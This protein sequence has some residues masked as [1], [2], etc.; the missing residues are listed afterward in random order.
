MSD[1]TIETFEY[2]AE[3]K[4][5]LHLIIH[6]LYTHPEVFLRE[7][8]SNASDA[9]NKVRY[10][11]LSD[12]T[13]I[14]KDSAL[15]IKISFDK[16]KKIFAI[17]DSGIGMTKE[18]LMTNIGT[19]ARSGTLE[20]LQKRQKEAKEGETGEGDLIGK[21]GVGFYSV[22]MVTDKVTIETRHASKD[23]QGLRWVS[24]GEGSYSIEDI[25]KET[26]GT[27][28]SFEVKESASE[29][30]EDYRVKDIIK[31]YSNFADFPIVIGDETINTVD[32]L[33]RKS[34]NDVT[35]DERNEF[36]KFITNDFEDPFGNLHLSIEGGGAEF[37]AL[38]FIPK[39]AA[40]DLIRTQQHKTVQLYTNKIMIMEDC[41][42]LLPEYLHFIRG[43]VD[44]SELSLNVSRETVQSSPVLSKIR[45]T[46]TTK[47]LQWLQRLA[48]KEPAKYIEFYKIFGAL[49]KSGLSADF[50]NRDKLIELMRF[51]SSKLKSEE[52]TSFKEYVGRMKEVDKNIYYLS[53]DNREVAQRNPNLEYFNKHDLEVLFLLDPADVFLVPSINEYDKKE[54]K[55]IDKGDID[56]EEGTDK[57]D[58]KDDDLTASLIKVFNETLKDDV[59][60][61]KVSKRLVDSAVTLVTGDS[62]VDPQMEKM[63][64][65]MGQSAPT[66]KRVL[67]VN[68]GHP[69]LKNLSKKYLAN[70]SDAIIK[71]CV[72]Q[73]YDSAQLLDGE[74][75]SRTSYVERMMD[76]M[77]EATR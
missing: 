23:A 37:K 47:I 31:K 32:A 58:A 64:K 41:K 77:A 42:E 33:W 28:I 30:V 19:V 18:N 2:K 22:F 56:L 73:L 66:S 74:L 48:N 6:S 12:E 57:K 8:I 16:E 17:E 49:F 26:R 11:Q 27:K 35:D 34:A 67:E 24:T 45:A 53:S 61:V 25:D 38:L 36:Y 4:Q 59:E 1:K 62:G 52:M 14:D 69:V 72:M 46:L 60:K 44:T 21:F 50:T 9:L 75:K 51:E 15:E 55:A 13:I 20:Y 3:M 76:I 70:P 10:A 54:I 7:L 43:V 63:M 40:Y 65:M 68:M 29:F 71:K 39:K 5:L